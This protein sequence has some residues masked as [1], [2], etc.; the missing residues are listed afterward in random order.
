MNTW[1][2]KMDQSYALESSSTAPDTSSPTGPDGQSYTFV[3]FARNYNILRYAQPDGY[4]SHNS[5]TSGKCRNCLTPYTERERID[6]YVY[7]KT[8]WDT[9]PN[10][11][12]TIACRC[13]K[14]GHLEH[15]RRLCITCPVLCR[16]CPA[17]KL[18]DGDISH[19][20]CSDCE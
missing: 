1:T 13:N 6:R 20:Y 9:Q 7:C 10:L 18:D 2:R 3:V 12:A 17:C 15:F 16:R 4:S 19:L 14:P 5:S 11:R 8:C